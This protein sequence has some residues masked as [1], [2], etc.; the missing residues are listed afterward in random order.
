M[1][2]EKRVLRRMFGL[3][4]DEVT[5]GG[6]KLHGVELHNL[7]SSPNIIGMISEGG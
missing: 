4:R 3:Q 1:E 5:G 7:Y 2:F 6:R